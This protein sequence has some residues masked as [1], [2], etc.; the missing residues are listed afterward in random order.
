MIA[1]AGKD[2]QAML[3]VLKWKSQI[4][5]RFGNYWEQR[6][7]AAIVSN[8]AM[9]IVSATN[10]PKPIEPDKR[11]DQNMPPNPTLDLLNLQIKQL[12]AAG[13]L[14][15]ALNRIEQAE[16][17]SYESR[18]LKLA[19][20]Y[21]KTAIGLLKRQL[22]SANKESQ[23][24]VSQLRKDLV[25]RLEKNAAK[26]REVEGSETLYGIAIKLIE[27]QLGESSE[28]KATELLAISSSRLCDAMSGTG[29]FSK[30]SQAIRIRLQKTLSAYRSKR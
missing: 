14:D 13:N 9:K 23:A 1:S 16:S 3:E 30:D 15:G 25:D 22:D 24:A 12:I 4:G 8:S 6:A 18:D 26:Y 10:T 7:E 29:P 17:V 28:P 27:S 5:D 21:S 20:G 19:F 2:Q 11:S